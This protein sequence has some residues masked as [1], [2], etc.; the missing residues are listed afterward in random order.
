MRPSYSAAAAA[1]WA[2]S[3]EGL[4]LGLVFDQPADAREPGVVL[5]EEFVVA[6]VVGHAFEKDAVL[7]Q[8]VP[9]EGFQLVLVHEPPHRTL[10]SP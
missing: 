5:V 3:A 1:P 8:H 7:L 4:A 2:A 9:V 10:P 6:R